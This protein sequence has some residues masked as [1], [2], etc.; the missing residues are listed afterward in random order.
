MLRTTENKIYRQGTPDPP[1]PHELEDGFPSK[2]EDLFAY[3]GLIIGSV[4]A[5]YF[6][7]TEQQLIRDFVDR[8]GGGLLFMGGRAALSDGGYPHRRWPTWCHQPAGGQR[9]FPQRLHGPGTH[10]RG[11]RERALPAG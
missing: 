11:R 4:E 3:Q 7:P 2:A 1:E 6:T 8:R 5:N 9:H 10:C